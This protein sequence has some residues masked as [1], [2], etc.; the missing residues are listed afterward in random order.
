MTQND[1][2]NKGTRVWNSLEIT[3]LLAEALLPIVLL[4][5]GN[6]FNQSVREAE[7]EARKTEAARAA[8]AAR[9]TAVESMSRFIYDRQARAALVVSSLLRNSP[10]DELR[11]RKKNYDETYIAWNANQQSNLLAVRQLLGE[12]RSYTPFEE[13]MENRLA[14]GIL[15]PLDACLTAAYDQRLQ[16]RDPLPILDQCNVSGRRVPAKALLQAALDCGYTFTDELFKLSERPTDARSQANATVEITRRCQIAPSD[17]TA[18]QEANSR[19]RRVPLSNAV[20]QT[21]NPGQQAR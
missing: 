15:A 13:L 1:R 5:V 16:A 10:L 3:K 7:A 19:S 17:T 6:Q 18:S 2:A 8:A 20:T 12:S 21:R 14:N 4:I 11:E 9:Q